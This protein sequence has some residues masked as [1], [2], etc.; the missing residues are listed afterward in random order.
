MKRILLKENLYLKNVVMDVSEYPQYAPAIINITIIWLLGILKWT[1]AKF[2]SSPQ[3]LSLTE[4]NCTICSSCDNPLLSMNILDKIF[5]LPLCS[6]LL[7]FGHRGSV[8]GEF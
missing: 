5:F 3:S 8:P 2:K 6:D 4:L 1:T 7:V